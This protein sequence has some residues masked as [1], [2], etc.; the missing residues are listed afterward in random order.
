MIIIWNTKNIDNGAI[1][2]EFIIT[3]DLKESVGTVCFSPSEKYIAATCNDE[4]HSLVVFDL[5]ELK[6]KEKDLTS[7]KTGIVASGPLIKS[8]VFDTR[9]ELDEQSLVVA[10]IREILFVNL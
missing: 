1:Q 7:T 5:Q 6:A 10:S 3:K 2:S 9:F 4:D 8:L